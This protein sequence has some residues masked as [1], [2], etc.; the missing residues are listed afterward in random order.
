[1]AFD[2]E[3]QE[4]AEAA[5]NGKAVDGVARGALGQ[6]SLPVSDFLDTSAPRWVPSVLTSLCGWWD[7]LDSTTLTLNGGNVAAWANKAAAATPASQ[8]TATAQPAYSATGRNNRPSVVFDGVDDV[9]PFTPTG[10]PSG[11]N[12]ITVFVV[13]HTTSSG[14]TNVF[15]YGAAASSQSVGVGISSGSVRGGLFGFDAVSTATPWTS[16]DQIVN[17]FATTGA[18]SLRVNGASSGVA[19]GASTPALSATNG[20]IGGSVNGTVWPGSIQEILVFSRALTTNERQQVEGY[21]AWRWGLRD[22]LRQGHP[23]RKAPPGGFATSGMMTDYEKFLLTE[24]R[25]EFNPNNYPGATQTLRVQAA[26]AAAKALG[27][28]ARLRLGRDTVS[29]PYTSTWLITQAVTIPT[30][31]TLLLDNCLLKRAD[32]I[33]DN[34]VRNDGIVPNSADPNNTVTALNANQNIRLIGIGNAKLEGST[35]PYAASPPGGGAAVPWVG[36]DFGWR[37]SNVQFANVRGL[38]VAGFTSNYPSA[39]AITNSHGV[40][41]FWYHDLNFIS[42]VANGD[43][44]DMRNGCRNGRIERITGATSDDIVCVFAAVPFADGTYYPMLPAGYASNPLGD[45]TYNIV[46]DTVTGSSSAS[47]VRAFTSGAQGTS[48]HHITINNVHQIASNSR[49]VEIGTFG[50]YTPGIGAV[51]NINVNNVTAD[52]VANAVNITA[53]LEDCSFNNIWAKNPAGV[54]VNWSIPANQTNSVRVTTTNLKV[55]P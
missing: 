11:S 5:L 54:A 34:V 14:S 43:G 33:F 50:T 19:G 49:C 4:M 51:N 35:T 16:Q 12:P 29:A 46:I 7:A 47:I 52:I 3:A 36:D 55:G 53:V 38:E 13:G 45:D 6:I 44:I 17:F 41:N 37:A 1:M 24:T 23:Y 25:Q 40:E 48:L 31:V 8:A 2:P 21:L 22:N 27:K 28:P 15:S 42:A 39:W 20:R 30:N 18:A 9:L 26:M 32:G 10:F